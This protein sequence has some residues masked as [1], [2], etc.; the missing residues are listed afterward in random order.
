MPYEIEYDPE[1]KLDLRALRADLR[2][3][4]EDGVARHLAQDAERDEGARKR[5]RPNPVAEWKL[6]L[7]PV[8]VYYDVEGTTVWVVAIILKAR[9][10]LYRRGKE[11][12]L[13]E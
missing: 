5:L 3:I 7:D 6:R 9:N 12:R 8:R 10:R 4:A 1:A 2:G 13:D 11:F